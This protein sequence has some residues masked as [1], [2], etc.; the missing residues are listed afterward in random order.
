MTGPAADEQVPAYVAG[1]GLPGLA[2]IHVHFMPDRVLR[3]VWAYFDE[4]GHRFGTGWPIQYRTGQAERL[5]TLRALGVRAIPA[6]NYAHRPGMA[7]W[8]NEWTA[9]F[10]AAEPDVVPCATFHAEPEAPGYVREALDAGARLFKV[11]VQVGGFDPTDP[12]LDGV[13]GQLEDAGVPVVLHAG[14]GPHP[15]E[16]TGPAPVAALLR[17]F[18]RLTLVIA[19]LG[20]PQYHEFADLAEAYPRVHLDTTMSGTDFT[21]AIAPMPA[22]YLRRL[23]DL[24][25]RVVLGS[26]F[27]NIPYPY[28]HQLEALDRLGLGEDWLRAVLWHNGARL[29]GL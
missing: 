8:L 9:G 1:L 21:E 25:D 7:A 19:H 2:D 26:D 15:G 24:G 27:P 11:H 4:H 29:L 28:A 13:W 20:M 16:H 6:L 12:V 23:A 5:A 10:A 17:R 3:K 22:G 18:P 14:S